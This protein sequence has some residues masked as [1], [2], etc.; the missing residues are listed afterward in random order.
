M[1]LNDYREAILSGQPV[2]WEEESVYAAA[3][4]MVRLR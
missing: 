4:G 3:D 1:V 2:R